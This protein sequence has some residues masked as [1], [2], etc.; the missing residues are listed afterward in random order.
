VPVAGKF[1]VASGAVDGLN[2]VFT[3]STA[4]Q[5]NSVAVFVNGAL[6]RRDLADGWSETNPAVGEVTLAEA[7]NLG[8]VVQIFFIEAGAANDTVEMTILIGKLVAVEDLSAKLLP[9]QEMSGTLTS[10]DL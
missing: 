6:H 9:V 3:V 1:E 10:G 8:D 4:Y 7:P 2:T 5:P